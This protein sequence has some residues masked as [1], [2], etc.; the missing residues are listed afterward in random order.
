M[1]DIGHGIFTALFLIFVARHAQIVSRSYD[2]HGHTVTLI[3]ECTRGYI[4]QVL[5]QKTRGGRDAAPVFRELISEIENEIRAK[6]LLVEKLTSDLSMDTTGK[7]KA[8]QDCLA[9]L[10]RTYGDLNPKGGDSDMATR[11]RLHLPRLG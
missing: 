7:T 9:E 3:A 11:S 5:D 10:K 6:P 2:R 8:V 4:L 1:Q